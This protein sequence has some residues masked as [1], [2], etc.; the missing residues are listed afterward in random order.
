MSAIELYHG[1]ASTCSKK[2]RLCLYEKGLEFKSHLLDL[3]RFEQ[4]RPQYLA[5]NPNG[6]VPTLVDGGRVIFESSIIIEYIEDAYPQNTLR[7]PDPFDRAQMR[8][9]LKFSDEVAYKAIYAPTWQRLRHRAAAGL[10]QET[11]TE[12]LEQIPDPERRN[13]WHKMATGGYSEAELEIAYEQMRICLKRLDERLRT[14]EWLA[15]GEFSL[16]DIALLPFIDRISNLRPDL[17]SGDSYSAL[18]FWFD[19]CSQR[20]S[21]RRAFAFSDDPR[22]AALPNF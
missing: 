6:V 11:L 7:P 15:G 14:S 9:W 18:R 16:A 10:S 8:L 2:V 20:D 12:T 1:L 21:F 22:A 3:Q 13:R 19:T 17:I 4:H 5:L